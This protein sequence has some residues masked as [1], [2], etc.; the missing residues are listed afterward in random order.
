MKPFVAYYNKHNDGYVL[1]VPQA[2]DLSV[3][4]SYDIFELNL[5][6]LGKKPEWFYSGNLF[7][8]QLEAYFEHKI[9]QK[10]SDS[11]RARLFLLGMDEWVL[12]DD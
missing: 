5:N 10:L 11:E 2:R 4:I 1:I 7:K 3:A 12:E 8:P 6:S 9:Y